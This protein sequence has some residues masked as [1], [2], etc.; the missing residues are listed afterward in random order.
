MN[1][2]VNTFENVNPPVGISFEDI[3]KNVRVADLS[4][5][6][7]ARGKEGTLQ[8]IVKEETYKY[9]MVEIGGVVYKIRAENL[10]LVK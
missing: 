1:C 4:A 2:M 9:G 5:N 6:E 8:S 3:G 10:A 7:E